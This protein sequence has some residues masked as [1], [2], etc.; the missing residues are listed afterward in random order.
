MVKLPTRWDWFRA[1]LWAI[2]TPG[3]RC[4]HRSHRLKAPCLLHFAYQ[5]VCRR[6]WECADYCPK[7]KGVR[8]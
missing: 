7:R 4:R 3:L 5:G 6:H 1:H 2:V 8:S